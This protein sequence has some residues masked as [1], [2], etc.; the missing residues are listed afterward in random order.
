ML[1]FIVIILGG[2]AAYRL[3]ANSFVLAIIVIV[4][5]LYQAS[6]WNEMMKE[7]EGLQSEDR[8]QSL[9]N[10]ITTIVIVILLVYSFLI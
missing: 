1:G 4:A 6:S 9:I 10:I 8:T 7:V 5:T 3:W 2:I